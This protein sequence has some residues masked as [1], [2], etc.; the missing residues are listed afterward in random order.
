MSSDPTVTEVF[1]EIEP[2]PDAILGAFDADSPESVLEGAGEHDPVPDD[3]V[4]A[5]DVTASEVFADLKA[6]SLEVSDAETRD[7]P[8]AETAYATGHHESGGRRST[9]SDGDWKLVGPEPPATRI[10]NDAFGG[11]GFEP[12]GDATAEFA[13]IDV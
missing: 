8:A 5:D 1:E 13:W 6:I 11:F 4:D 10:E 3:A 9:A 12:D 2:D 7:E